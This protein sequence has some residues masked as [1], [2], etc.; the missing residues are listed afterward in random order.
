[1]LTKLKELRFAYSRTDID[2]VFTEPLYKEIIGSAQFRRLRYISFLGVLEY[3]LRSAGLSREFAHSRFNHSIGVAL[4]ALQYSRLTSKSKDVER[5]LVVHSLLHDIGHFPFSHSLEDFFY[6]KFKINHHIVLDKILSC[7]SNYS[8]E[9][10]NILYRHG[11]DSARLTGQIKNTQD[12]RAGPFN[13]DTIEGITRVYSALCQPVRSTPSKIME[14]VFLENSEDHRALFWAD[15]KEA[16]EKLINSPWA[17]ASDLLCSLYLLER[18]DIKY[19]C[20]TLNDRQFI[21]SI[22]DFALLLSQIRIYFAESGD[23]LPRIPRF[24]HFSIDCR[25]DIPLDQKYKSY[26][27]SFSHNLDAWKQLLYRIREFGEPTNQTSLFSNV[28]SPE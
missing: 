22:P 11:Y 10:H 18:P 12:V 23:K 16:Y 9:I 28:F 24:R 1:M 5:D 19:E 25:D 17:C 13:I 2:S 14:R 26:K 8:E 7:E 21:E 4:L 27:E 6:S 15:K 3:I 20:H